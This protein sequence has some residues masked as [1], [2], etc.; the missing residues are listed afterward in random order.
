MG[1]RTELILVDLLIVLYATCYQLQSPLEPYLVE[2]LSSAEDAAESYAN[3]RSF[4]S[5]IQMAGSLGVGHIIDRA[6][7]RAG[8]AL[9]FVSCAASYAILMRAETMQGLFASK[10]PTL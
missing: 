9:N 1:L 8:M 5:F 4:F 6:G 3:L 7:V 2:K 10:L